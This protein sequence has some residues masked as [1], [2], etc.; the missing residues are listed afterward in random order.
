MTTDPGT[1]RQTVI[2]PPFKQTPY[3]GTPL[4]FALHQLED[5]RFVRS[6]LGTAIQCYLR[7]LARNLQASLTV[8]PR[9]HLQE[10]KDAAARQPALCQ[11]RYGN[12]AICG[13]AKAQRGG[14]GRWGLPDKNIRGGSDVWNV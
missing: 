1:G 4:D 2:F 13:L 6:T 11:S 12:P 14:Q 3:H 10:E 7:P 8:K 5:R 9:T